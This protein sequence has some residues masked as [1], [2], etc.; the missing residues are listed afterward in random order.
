MSASDIATQVRQAIAELLDRRSTLQA[1]EHGLEEE[2]AQAR[3]QL[4]RK[5]L[6]H[7]IEQGEAECATA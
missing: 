3:E 4:R 2:L 5:G 7:L 1:R 6:L